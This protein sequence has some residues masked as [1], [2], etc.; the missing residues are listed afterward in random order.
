LNIARHAY[1]DNITDAGRE[2]A[3]SV[4]SRRLFEQLSSKMAAKKSKKE[5]LVYR[6][7]ITSVKPLVE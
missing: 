3:E 6:A 2:I 5:H 7:K 4:N 1:G